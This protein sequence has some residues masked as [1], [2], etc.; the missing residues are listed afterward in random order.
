MCLA[1]P[2]YQR[3]LPKLLIFQQPPQEDLAF[4][5]SDHGNAIM[6]SSWETSVDAANYIHGQR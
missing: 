2:S 5:V 3:L 4:A 1:H 6:R